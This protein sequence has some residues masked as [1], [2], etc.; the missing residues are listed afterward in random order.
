MY[1]LTIVYCIYFLLNKIV[2]QQ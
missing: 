1:I 2:L